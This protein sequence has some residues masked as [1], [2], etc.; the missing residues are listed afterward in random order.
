MAADAL[1]FDLDGTIWDSAGWFAA[2]L[3]RGDAAIE[4]GLR[5]ELMEGGNIIGALTRAG[6]TR[7]RLLAESQARAGPPP[8]FDGMR[9]ALDMLSERGT[10]LAVATSLPGTLAIPMLRMAQ[11]DG[12]FET[13]VHAGLC[14]T[15]KPHPRSLLMALTGLGLYASPGRYYVGDRASDRAAAAAAGLS[16]AWMA[17]GYE[18][19][20]REMNQRTVG[21]AE[22]LGL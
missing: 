11:L 5:S 21:A 12:V 1:I 15:P 6:V 20:T 16:S 10:R 14:R 13:V 17:H 2:G 8:L 7:N 4:A 9:E 19:P 18:Q 3:S 22:L